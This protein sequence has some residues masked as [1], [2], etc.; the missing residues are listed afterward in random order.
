MTLDLSGGHL[1]TVSLNGETFITGQTAV[2]LNLK[3]GKNDVVVT[4]DLECQGS[5]RESFMMEDKMSVF[6]NPV[7]DGMLYLSFPSQENE[8]VSV[9]VYSMVGKLII[10]KQLQ[11]E[12]NQIGVNVNELAVGSYVVKLVSNTSIYNSKFIRQ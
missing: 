7:K 1:Y 3:P 4:T 11:P 12:N 10:D 8:K 5:Y 9:Q 6:P 2:T